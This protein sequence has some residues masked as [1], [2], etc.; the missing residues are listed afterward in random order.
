M[1]RMIRA[2]LVFYCA[3]SVLAVFSQN[4]T[5]A[6]SV[7]NLIEN[8]NLSLTE[9][10]EAYYR[11]SMH[12]SSP[13][14]ELKYGNQLL[15]LAKKSNNQEYIIKA[16][17][18]IGVA[19]RLLGNLGQALKN[20]F[21]SAQNASEKKEFERLLI[22][23]YQEISTCYTQNGDSEN[24]MHYG[25]KT[26]DLLRTTGN[27]QR[28]ALTLL[29]MGYD[30]Y[31]IE[32][33]DSAMVYYNESAVLLEEINMDRA[34]AY[35]I[36]NRALVYWKR[37]ENERAKED[38]LKAIEMLESYEDRFGMADYYNQMGR[39]F[40]EEN[41]QNEAIANTM[42]GLEMA[43]EEGMKEQV[44]DASNLLFLLHQNAGEHKTAIG[45]QTQYHA[46]KDSIQNFE[47]TQRLANLRTK[48]EVGQKQAEVDLLLEQKRSNQIIMITGGIILAIVICLVIIVYSHSRAKMRLNRK[49]EVQKDSLIALNDTKDKFFAIIAHDLRGPV[50]N[51]G[52]LVSVSQYFLEDKKIDQLQGMMD[53]MD[54]SVDSLVKLLD[55]LL[56]WSLQQK[57][58]FPYKPELL[59][60]PSIL[61]DVKEMFLDMASSKDIQLDLQVEEDFDV[62]VD[63]NTTSTLLRNLLNNAIKFTETG[64]QVKVIADQNTET[65]IATIKIIDSGVGIPADKLKVLFQLNENI[66]TRGTSGEVGLG[67][68][69]QLVYEFVKLNEGQITVES[70]EGK[71]TTFTLQ[72]PLDGQ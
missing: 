3:L 27:R 52:G 62:F 13:E 29:N 24:A 51:L 69:L 55:N 50:N 59:S 17:L 37:G 36:G 44:R 65:K 46:Y 58:H 34:V 39:I 48:Y 12:S 2:G 35:I 68:G 16:N 5:K 14:D 32:K 19:Q 40:F 71:G 45:Y 57:G 42:M 63:K 31:L 26:I 11:L 56:H 67:L 64:G 53:R 21:E 6:D 7:R 25:V 60:L 22:D 30:Y 49:L 23:I 33:Y 66:T 61:A 43:K 15:E 72:F 38:L 28:L 41:N 10:L 54:R 18:R 9:E 70:E 1:R 47:T 20:L 4:Q 8:G